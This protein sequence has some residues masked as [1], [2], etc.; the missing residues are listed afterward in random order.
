MTTLI[1]FCIGAFALR[2]AIRAYQ[3]A[4]VR[5]TNPEAWVRLQELEQQQRLMR[6]EGMKNV[7]GVGLTIARLL[8][9]K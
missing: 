7:A 9:K 8:L 1:M 5:K 6:R 2:A 3:Q 4:E